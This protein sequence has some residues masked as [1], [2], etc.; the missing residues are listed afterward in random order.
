[1]QCVDNHVLV[2][3]SPPRMLLLQRLGTAHQ[4][5]LHCTAL[6]CTEHM[7]EHRGI[8]YTNICA[9]SYFMGFKQEGGSLILSRERVLAISKNK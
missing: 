2:S 7:A 3:S 6:H 8:E 9:A 1:M 4:T 5:L